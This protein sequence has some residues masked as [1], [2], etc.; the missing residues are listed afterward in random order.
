[1]WVAERIIPQ[2]EKKTM[3]ETAEVCLE[4]LIQR[5]LVQVSSRHPNGSIKDCQVHDLVRDLAIHEATKENFISVF[6]KPQDSVN[7]L[8][9]V[10]RRASLQ[11]N[12]TEYIDYV[13]PTTR[14]LFWFGQGSDI[15]M[16]SEFKLLRILEIDYVKDFELRGIDRL[17]HLKYLGIKF[18]SR[19]KFSNGCSLGRLKNLETL[20]LRETD[21]DND[22]IPMGLWTIDTL[23]HAMCGESIVCGPPSNAHLRNLQTLDCISVSDAWKNQ[24]PCLKNL[25]ELG[26][27]NRHAKNFD[28]VASLLGTLSHLLSLSVENRVEGQYIPKKIVYPTMIPNYQNLQSLSLWGRWSKGVTLEASSFPPHLVKLVL[29]DSELRQDPMEELG[30]LKNL[31]KLKLY[32]KVYIGAEEMICP[33]GFPVLENLYIN[34]DGAESFTVKEGSEGVMPKL[35]HLENDGEF[36]ALYMP[37][38]LE[39]FDKYY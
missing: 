35:K 21:L 4:Q 12:C 38:E 27:V 5:S 33:V 17:I 28:G 1:M 6:P 7:H 31:K 3:E 34:L 13:T 25:R 32:G 8:D 11:S 18:C 36:I 19:L 9:R 20:D 22:D 39:H 30:K 14:S 37:P 16:Y 10:T 23:R 26:V 15:P 24:V 29:S 2:Q